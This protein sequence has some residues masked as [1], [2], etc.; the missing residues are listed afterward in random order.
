[1]IG[2]IDNLLNFTN[3]LFQ[4][5]ELKPI[6]SQLAT[7]AQYMWERGWAERNAGN[8]SVNLTS[9]FT[10]KELERLTTYPFYPFSGRFPELVGN[11]FLVSGTG[12]R[13]RDIAVNP[14]DHV[15]FLYMAEQGD[16]F[17]IINNHHEGAPTLPTSE[18]TTHLTIHQRL[19]RT[20]SADKVV[21]H[22]HVTELIAL[23]QL[24]AFQS[25]EAINKLLFGMHPEISLF[26]PGGVG[27]IPYT[28]AGTDQIAIETIKG[29]ASHKAVIWEK[30]GC[31]SISDSP[32]DAFDILDIV[33]KAARIFFLASVYGH[34]PEGLQ[35]DQIKEIR[36]HFPGK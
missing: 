3:D 20:L 18:L 30:H 28:L 5:R 32:D 9:F 2:T 33:A 27:Y 8:F 23:T 16:V 31:I 13:M 11:L 10:T 1:M 22:A 26:L 17:H 35:P 34:S 24:K 12:T 25:E 29:L 14:M 19:V 21:L 4:K 7:T 6:F 36:D 15:C